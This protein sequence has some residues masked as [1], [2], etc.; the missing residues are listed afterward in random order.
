MANKYS[1]IP[2]LLADLGF[3]I[4]F[5][6]YKNCTFFFEEQNFRNSIAKE[7]KLQKKQKKKTKTK[8]KNK[9]KNMAMSVVTE[10]ISA[11]F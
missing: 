8:T 3:L 11:W 4:G 2:R 10:I 9:Q 7:K 5:P 1:I 6:K